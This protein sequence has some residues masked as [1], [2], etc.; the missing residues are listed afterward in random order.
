M[1]NSK[2]QGKGGRPGLIAKNFVLSFP[3]Q[4]EQCLE[5]KR[6]IAERGWKT[7]LAD[8]EG[9]HDLQAYR[10]FVDANALDA[11]NDAFVWVKAF[12]PFN[13]LS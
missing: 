6:F 3:E 5:L 1:E 9:Q 10:P 8:G 7:L 2:I 13:N 12:L 11:V 4:V